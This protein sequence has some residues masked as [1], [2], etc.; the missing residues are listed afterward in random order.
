M[1]LTQEKVDR[2]LL[3]VLVLIAIILMAMVLTIFFGKEKGESPSP[4]EGVDYNRLGLETEV[5]ESVASFSLKDPNCISVLQSGDPDDKIDVTFLA[6]KYDNL[7]KFKR[8]VAYYIDPSGENN[9]LLGLEPFKSNRG[10]FNFY[11]VDQNNDLECKLGCF[12]IDRLV[13]CND[14]KVKQVASQC[15]SDKIFV[16]V[17]T[18]QFCGASK[19]YATVCTIT[20]PRAGLVL[21]H[22]FGHI[23]GKLGDEYSYGKEGTT[24]APNCDVAGC[25]KWRGVVG[26]GC[27]QTCGYTNLY[28]STDKGS[29]MNIYIPTFGPLGT[30]LLSEKLA[31]YKTEE[32]L[33]Q[34][35]A[36][37]PA[38][39]S[40]IISLEYENGLIELE[41]LFVTAS[42]FEESDEAD[43][44]GKIFSFDSE[45]LST[46]NIEIPEIAYSFYSP[47][48]GDEGKRRHDLALLNVQNFTFNAP[49]F[50][51]G[52]TLEISDLAGGVV[53]RVDLA[54][55]AET[56]GNNI[57]EEHE[58]YLECSN[59]CRIEDD[60]YCLPY[61][62]GICD[63][64]CP[65]VGK[66][67][68]SDCK[69]SLSLRV[70]GILVF[71]MISLV[72]LV[73]VLFWRKRKHLSK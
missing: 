22:E 57:C 4:S 55:F 14:D 60:N 3:I 61:N 12:G 69:R 72:L 30:K 29:L 36:A 59:D 68:D 19:D 1:A 67:A 44:V 38:N 58:T 52:K 24:P 31:E 50:E 66:L 53:E 28:R 47:D 64:D 43:Y 73:I 25:E 5:Y 45:V 17:D 33:E 48:E 70:A 10:K 15:P 46:F 62:D 42:E 51:N 34:I 35:K 39:Q 23:F 54:P 56:C 18:T 27:F 8:D 13:C 16:L 37:P 20:D 63:A 26:T 49:Y 71:L 41:N 65:S 7:E 40:Y 9:G 11:F 21:V 2:L 6:E 32:P